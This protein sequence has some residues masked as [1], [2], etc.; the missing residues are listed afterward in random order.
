LSSR[1]IF[2]CYYRLELVGFLIADPD[3]ILR[4]KPGT[5]HSFLLINGT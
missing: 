3:G 5:E 4:R 1:L 2:Y